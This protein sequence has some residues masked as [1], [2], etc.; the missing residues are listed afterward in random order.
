MSSA[1]AGLGHRS[2]LTSERVTVRGSR[3]RRTLTVS[4]QCSG[5]SFR[6]ACVA[7]RRPSFI[8]RKASSNGRKEEVGRFFIAPSHNRPRHISHVRILIAVARRLRSTMSQPENGSLSSTSRHTQTGRQSP[9]EIDGVHRHHDPHLWRDLDHASLP[10]SAPRDRHEIRDRRCHSRARGSCPHLLHEWTC[11][12][13]LRRQAADR[14]AGLHR[15]RTFVQRRVP[16][17]RVRR[18]PIRVSGKISLLVGRFTAGRR[19]NAGVG[20][21]EGSLTGSRATKESNSH[22]SLRQ[23]TQV[24]KRVS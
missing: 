8:W 21:C 4:A 22:T 23:R 1:S 7:V 15:V 3:R 24:S 11:D 6:Q 12:L 10:L 19:R 16:G 20:R 5:V 13:D 14:V 18:T 9:T 2:I 17:T